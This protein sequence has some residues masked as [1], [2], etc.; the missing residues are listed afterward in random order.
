MNQIQNISFHGQTVPVFTQNNQHYAAMKPI[1]ENIGIDWKSQFSKIQRNPILNSTM[2]M[3][4][5]VAQDG[6]NREMLCLPIEYLNGWLFGIDVNRVK[7]EIRDNLLRY[8]RECFK[9]LNAHFN[10]PIQQPRIQPFLIVVLPME[11]VLFYHIPH[12]S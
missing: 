6:K 7:P 8:Q 3:M 2:V 4:T 9:V 11:K 12:L 5:I 1:C 10:R